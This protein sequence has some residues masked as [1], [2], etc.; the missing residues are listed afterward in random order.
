MFM[1][2]EVAPTGAATTARIPNMNSN[3]QYLIRFDLLAIAAPA[4]A[5]KPPFGHRT[6]N[7]AGE[8]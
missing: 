1:V 2:I 4:Y 6:D 3:L 5:R 7:R 8:S